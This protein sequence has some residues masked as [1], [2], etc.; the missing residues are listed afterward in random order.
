MQRLQR[1]AVS[2]LHFEF[3][4]QRMQAFDGDTVAAALLANNYF[5][6]RS[7]PISAAARGPFCMMGVCFECL[8]E[9]DGV[10]NCQAC[11]VELRDGMRVKRQDGAVTAQ[12]NSEFSK[13]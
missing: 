6:F 13:D 9:I 3:E 10:Q 7:T 8:L 12:G 11:M 2:Q 1:G 4:G 5:D